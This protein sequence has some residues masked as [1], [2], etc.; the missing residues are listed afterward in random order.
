LSVKKVAI[1]GG[2]LTGL[3]AAIRAAEIGH[4]VDLFEAAPELGGRTRSCFHKPSQ[5]W[6]DHG[7]HLLIGVYERTIQ[8]LKDVDALKNTAWQDSLKLPLWDHKRGHFSLKTSPYLPF[9]LALMRAVQQMPE[10]GLAMIPSIL[11]LALSMKKYAMQ[12][13]Q[14]STVSEW[15]QAANIQK[16]LQRDMIEVLCLGAM[17]E[18]MDTANAASF[19]N[20]LQQ[21][22]A[23]HKT[24]RLGWFT[25]PLSQAFIEPIAQHCKTLGIRIHTSSRIQ[26]LQSNQQHCT[27][28]TRT[29]SKTYDKVILAIPPTVRNKLLNIE[30]M[31]ATRSITNI[32]LWF[33]EK[34][35]LSSPFI[36]GIGTYGQWFFDISHQFHKENE[37]NNHLSHLCAVISADTSTKSNQ[38]K[39]NSI[40]NELQQIMGKSDLKPIYQR[41]IAVQA[42]THL[43]RPVQLHFAL[44]NH[45]ID[46]CE[47][48]IHGE[49]PA[50]IE[51]AI[52]RGEQ[53]VLQLQ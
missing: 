49:L 32:H 53:A 24:A 37:G 52:V 48:P 4:H 31:I 19:A 47:Q 1:I 12:S 16:P 11:R 43:V 25:A 2:G 45:L 21:A 42:A 7:P 15:M 51:S 5:T 10:H 27:L 22:F 9:P 33:D 38:E 46:A 17:N 44:P 41:I 6:I 18:A 50:T 29:G 28:S 23:N 30:Q 36:G 13:E 3:S 8:L 35:T 39:I 20:V 26:S 14:N 40:I 34:I